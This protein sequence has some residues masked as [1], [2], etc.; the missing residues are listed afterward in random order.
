MFLTQESCL[1][2]WAKI[3]S[4][5][6]PIF[7]ERDVALFVTWSNW[8]INEVYWIFLIVKGTRPYACSTYGKME[9]RYLMK[10][11]PASLV[12]GRIAFRMVMHN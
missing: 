1:A 2:T 7:S 4:H 9:K 5:F 6:L 11:W 10:K 3:L 8:W 12:C